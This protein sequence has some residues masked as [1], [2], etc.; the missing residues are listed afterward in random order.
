MNKQPIFFA[1]SSHRVLSESVCRIFGI[2]LGRIHLAQFPDG[3]TDV[4]IEEDVRG[5]D[6]FILQ[7]IARHPDAY[8]FELLVIID[9][10]K[11]ASARSITTVIPYLGYC[12]QD[13]KDKPGSP[14]TA[15]L[16]A[17]VLKTAG[18]THLLTFDLHSD[19]L[20]GFFETT[21]DHLHC[22]KLLG[23]H[24]KEQLGGEGCVVVAADIG[25]VKIAERMT[26]CLHTELVVINKERRSAFEV[27]M[28]LIGSVKGKN[29]VIA[30]DLCSTAGTL[31]TAANLCKEQGA[32][33]VLGAITHG[34]FVG[35]AIANIEA[36]SLDCLLITDTIEPQNVVSSSIR[37]VSVAPLIAASIQKSVS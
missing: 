18:T 9:A 16:V 35:D 36:S 23:E 26:K 6:V 24:A 10:A 17:N 11:R 8:L 12:R 28:T 13:R 22:Q 5:R 7:S 25:G 34:L 37:T 15:K 21:V 32:K 31:V 27:G 3:E 30:D 4:Q 2:P 33:K 1:G 20:E 19:Q 14:I 29:V